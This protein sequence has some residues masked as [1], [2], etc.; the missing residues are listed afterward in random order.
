MDQNMD[1]RQYYD[2]FGENEWKRLEEN[3]VAQLEYENTIDILEQHLPIEGKILDAGGGPGR[4]S[5]WLADHGFD[6]EHIDFS[7]KQVAIARDKVREYELSDHITCQQ[8][9][10]RE[11]PFAENTFDAVCCLGGPISHIMDPDER[12]QAIGEL[13]RVAKPEGVIFVSV[14]GRL[15]SVLHGIRHG[16]QKHP[17]IIPEIAAHGDYTAELMENVEGEGWAE[18]HF[19]RVGEFEELLTST[20]LTITQI[21]GLEGLA[22]GMQPE[23]NEAPEEAI[24]YVTDVVKMLQEDRSVADFSEHI[25]AVCEVEN[26]ETNY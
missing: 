6:V 21:I 19:F 24:D 1:P 8:G 14:I 17:E 18:C 2:D 20:R 13:R 23:L 26:D 5:I 4:Y 7:A 10:I 9:D 25:L 22:S 12:E 16:L 15:A 3:P 11:I